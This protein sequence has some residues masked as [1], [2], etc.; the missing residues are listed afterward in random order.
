MFAQFGALTPRAIYFS[1]S[2]PTIVLIPERTL[3]L[4]LESGKINLL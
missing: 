4:I 3:I 1:Q 2:H